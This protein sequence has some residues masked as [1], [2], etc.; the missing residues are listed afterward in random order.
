MSERTS[1][2]EWRRIATSPVAGDTLRRPKGMSVLV[3]EV[4][5]LAGDGPADARAIVLYTRGAAR[6]WMTLNEWQRWLGVV[7]VSDDALVLVPETVEPL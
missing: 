3:M 7:P 4:A 2:E 1:V 5:Y 6:E